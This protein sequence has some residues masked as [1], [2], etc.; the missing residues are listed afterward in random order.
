MISLMDNSLQCSRGQKNL[1]S[2]PRTSLVLT[3]PLT[4]ALSRPHQR[5]SIPS[6]GTPRLSGKELGKIKHVQHLGASEDTGL[7][8]SP[9]VLK[10][11]VTHLSSYAEI[12][13]LHQPHT[14]QFSLNASVPLEYATINAA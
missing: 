4:A 3:W 12:S 5:F 9:S 1:R 2:H 8:Y 11:S 13:H 10:S 6:S 7:H 14:E